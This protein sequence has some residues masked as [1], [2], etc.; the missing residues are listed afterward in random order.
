MNNSNVLELNNRKLDNCLFSI[1]VI[2]IKAYFKEENSFSE[3][4]EL[5]LIFGCNIQGKRKYL[6]TVFKEDFAK[7]SDWYNFLLSLKERGIQILL[8]ALIPNNEYL[9]KALNLAFKEIKVYI[10][11]LETFIKLKK[12]YTIS[13]TNK[14]FENIRKLYL[15]KSIEEYETQLEVFNNEY[16][17][18]PFIYDLFESDVKRAKQYYDTE[19]E[20]RR[21]IFSFYFCR[22][23]FKKLIVISHSKP[24]FSSIED[25][26]TSLLPDIQRIELRMF[27]PKKEIKSIINK[28]YEDKKD[29]IKN[30]L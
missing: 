1:I 3:E 28:I 14:V 17:Q 24:N 16:L 22:E 4:K 8:Y 30:Y 19:Y 10:S 25:F 18:T 12:Y 29:L 11:F 5:Y 9:S 6:T 26:V 20:F 15:S 2:P 13:Y 21:F 27:C 7:T 23:L